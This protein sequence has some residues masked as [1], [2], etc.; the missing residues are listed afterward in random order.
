MA[1]NIFQSIWFSESSGRSS[2][3]EFLFIKEK[4][5]K[6]NDYWNFTYKI[7]KFKF[8]VCVDASEDSPL[9]NYCN[10]TS[11]SALPWTEIISGEFGSGFP[12]CSEI[13]LTLSTMREAFS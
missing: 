12:I 2:S 7:E 5:L 4:G 3:W 11:K 6:T 10:D 13:W 1:T 9:A 8:S